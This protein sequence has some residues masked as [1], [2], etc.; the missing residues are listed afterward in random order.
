MINQDSVQ[1]VAEARLN[2]GCLK[3]LYDDYGFARIPGLVRTLLTDERGDGSHGRL[4]GPLHDR[5]D[6]VVLLLIDAFGWRFVEHYA[7]RDPFLERVFAE[8]MVTKLTSQFPS[9][10]AAHVTTIHTGLPVGASGVFEW[11]YYEP[12]VD[13]L[14]APLMYSY[15]GDKANDTLRA[16]GV[17]PEQ[18]YPTT[19]LYQ[20]LERHGVRSYLFQHRS[21]AYSP[22]SQVVSEGATTVPYA[23]LAEALVNLARHV[24]AQRE[25]AYYCLYFDAIDAVCHRYGPDSP[26][27]AAEIELFLTAM[28]RIFLR[29][30]AGSR[31]RVLYLMTADHGQIGIDPAT[32]VY[33][34]RACPEIGRFFR[35][36]RAGKLLV[37][38]GS[39]RD[40]FLYVHDDRLEEAREL[41]Q[42]QLEGVAEVH[43]IADLIAHG[44]FGTTHPSEQLLGR[45]GNLVVLP[46]EGESVW[47][48]EQGRFEQNF[49]GSH[50]GL[51]RDEMETQLLAWR[52]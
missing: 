3:P 12:L 33:L 47:W 20:A 37:P 26:Q 9:T 48:Y 45:I 41:L 22:Y 1:A 19:T 23:T 32:T 35:A 46:Y 34:N 7:G 14:I 16:S 38:G 10:T 36:N 27:L 31:R 44:Y 50:G 25:R 40:M 49:Y 17:S 13:Q 30:L 8:G 4:L 52:A 29:S 2:R 15:A 28:E 24:E 5:Y 43:R 51:T 21:Y 42:R 6:I 18:L 39:P 11:F